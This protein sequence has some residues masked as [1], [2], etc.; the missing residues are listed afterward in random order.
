MFSLRNSHGRYLCGKDARR[1]RNRE[2]AE[3]PATRL[4]RRPNFERKRI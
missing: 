3:P 2:E 4:H 1:C